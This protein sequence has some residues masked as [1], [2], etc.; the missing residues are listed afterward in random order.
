MPVG[1]VGVP[2]ACRVAVA[3][4]MRVAVAELGGDAGVVGAARLISDRIYAA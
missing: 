1:G 2:I 4:R 3:R